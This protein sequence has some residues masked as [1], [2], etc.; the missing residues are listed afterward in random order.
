M[1]RWK[2]GAGSSIIRG[3]AMH[4]TFCLVFQAFAAAELAGG[5]KKCSK[6]R[7]IALD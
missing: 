5:E 4:T 1:L 3:Q 2:A 6:V 7:D